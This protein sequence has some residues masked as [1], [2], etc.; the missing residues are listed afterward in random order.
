MRPIADGHTA[1]GRLRYRAGAAAVLL[2]SF[3]WGAAGARAADLTVNGVLAAPAQVTSVAASE[4]MQAWAAPSGAGH[5]FAVVLRRAGHNRVLGATSAVG[6]IDSVKLGTDSRGRSIVV[7][8]RC[9]HDPFA[10]APAGEAGTDGCRL[11]W[12]STSAG[13]ARP[14][15]AAPADSSIGAAAGGLVT[16][17]VQANSGHPRQAVRLERATLAGRNARALVV[18]AASGATIDDIGLSG[19]SI[20]FSEAGLTANPREG[21]SEIWL[22]RAGLPPAMIARVLSD[23]QPVDNAER[24][25]QGLTLTPSALYAFLYSQ[26]GV[27]PATHSL[28][29]RISLP[30][31]ETSTATWAPLSPLSGL[32][33]HSEAYDPSD[34]RLTLGL[35][36][37]LVDFSSPASICSVR[38]SS[39]RACPVLQTAPAV[40][41]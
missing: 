40:F 5:R 31:L 9:P 38:P 13:L 34:G 7:Y 29:E 18:P 41:G 21:F 37:Q 26:S 6:W 28:L 2:A 1:G 39:D 10:S 16:F 23:A 3:A 17:A 12:A 32:G 24:F 22:E 33:L 35:F 8:S 11:W 14:I 36:T 19:S 25:F 15:A 27:F 20:A 30:G 4:G